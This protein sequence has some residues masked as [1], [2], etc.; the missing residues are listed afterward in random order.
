MID[1]CA[2]DAAPGQLLRLKTPAYSIDYLHIPST[3]RHLSI[4]TYLPIPLRPYPTRL[5]PTQDIR[6]DPDRGQE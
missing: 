2:L 1:T 3:T 5:E 4:S 6:L